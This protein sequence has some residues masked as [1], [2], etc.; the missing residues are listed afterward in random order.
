M[1]GQIRANQCR[2]SAIQ[3]SLWGIFPFRP[4]GRYG[5]AIVPPPSFDFL[6]EHR[7]ADVCVRFGGDGVGVGH[8]DG[9]RAAFRMKIHVTAGGHTGNKGNILGWDLGERRFD[10]MQS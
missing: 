10:Y 5:C 9:G 3:S 4:R 8:P 6:A 7:R 1:S 2:L